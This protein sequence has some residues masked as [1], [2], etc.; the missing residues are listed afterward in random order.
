LNH[1]LGSVNK[2]IKGVK[3]KKIFLSVVFTLAILIGLMAAFSS[4]VSA[5]QGHGFDGY[6]G[7]GDGGAVF[8]MTNPNGAANAVI[9]FSRDNHGAL[10]MVGSFA[11][12][13][14]GGLR[15]GPPDPLK[16]QGSLMLTQ[17]GKWLLAVNAGSNSISVFQVQNNGL[18]L[19]GTTASGGTFPVSLTISGNEVFVLN[20]STPNITGFNL[21]NKGKLTSIAGSTDVLPSG[22]SYLYTQVGFDNYGKWLVVSDL[23]D[24]AILAAPV[25]SS[26][27]PGAWQS[28][29]S[30]G[31]APFGFIFDARDNLLVVQAGNSAVSS[32][33]VLSNGMLSPI[34]EA[35]NPT[36]STSC[37]IVEDQTDDVFTT[38]PGTN[39]ISSYQDGDNSGNVSWLIPSAASGITTIDEGITN[40]GDFLYALA[41]GVGID[42]YKISHD[43]TL[44]PVG[45]FPATGITGNS[46][47][48]AVW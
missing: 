48:I 27:I 3:M 10:N 5:D 46:Q 33:R 31:P 22:G 2:K 30:S 11:T 9:M 39:N 6:S 37:W 13:G 8:T 36:S 41:P 4:G 12:G 26:G 47:G 34:V 14:N 28:S 43:G 40:G 23:G 42:G 44:K 17:D 25:N 19:I 32:Y 38:N 15:S 20:A 24:S 29:P 21:S 1:I 18:N 45:T 7:P 16:S 35:F